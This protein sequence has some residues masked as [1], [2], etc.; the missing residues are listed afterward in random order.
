MQRR[1][2][3]GSFGTLRPQAEQPASNHSNSTELQDIQMTV[4]GRD[5]NSRTVDDAP[6][7]R[8]AECQPSMRKQGNSQE[9]VRACCAFSF[10]LSDLL[11]GVLLL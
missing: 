5:A 9:N 11:I 3:K 1:S 6:C 4:E 8:Q 10:I 2:R 7:L